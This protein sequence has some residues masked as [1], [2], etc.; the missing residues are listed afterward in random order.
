MDG[1]ARVG[2]DYVPTT[3]ARSALPLICFGYV[4]KLLMWR[5]LAFLGK[6]RKIGPTMAT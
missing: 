4:A 6:S 3:A 5:S 2:P 1:R